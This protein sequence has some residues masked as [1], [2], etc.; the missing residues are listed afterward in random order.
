MILSLAFIYAYN[1][2]GNL[3]LQMGNKYIEFAQL[4]HRVL[5]G[6][7]LSSFTDCDASQIFHLSSLQSMKADIQICIDQVTVK[8]LH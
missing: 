6:Y 1:I 8:Q 5:Y 2:E 3:K 7:C 4:K